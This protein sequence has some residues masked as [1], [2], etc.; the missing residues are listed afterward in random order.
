MPKHSILSTAQ[1]QWAWTAWRFARWH[2]ASSLTLLVKLEAGLLTAVTVLQLTAFGVIDKSGQTGNLPTDVQFSFSGPPSFDEA[3]SIRSSDS[4][5][6]SSSASVSSSSNSSPSDSSPSD[7]SSDSSSSDSSPGSSSSSSSSSSDDSADSSSIQQDIAR[8]QA[9][10]SGSGGASASAGDDQVTC[11]SV[12]LSVLCIAP[13]TVRELQQV[14]ALLSTHVV[15]YSIESTRTASMTARMLLTACMLYSC[16]WCVFVKLAIL[17]TMYCNGLQVSAYD[18]P[19]PSSPKASSPSS[20]GSGSTPSPRS[21]SSS[22]SSS[23][24]SGTCKDVS[25]GKTNCS[26]E[27]AWGHCSVSWM[28]KASAS[29]PKGYCAQTCGRC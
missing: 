16:M 25:P 1:H 2:A 27:K 14:S 10:S 11:L 21:S 6:D 24:S 23:S 26:Q 22:P 19:A 15:S 13:M 4:S 12:H 29:N 7:S 3:S 20:K 9:S 18:G 5:S 17:V 8:A 28:K